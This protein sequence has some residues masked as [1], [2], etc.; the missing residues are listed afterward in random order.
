ML[1]KLETKEGIISIDRVVIN[2]IIAE[3]I[4]AFQGKVLISNHKGKVIGRS[5]K[6]NLGDDK[7]HSEIEIGAKGLDIRVYIVIRFGTSINKVTEQ[8]LSTIKGNIEEFLGIEV[9]SIAIVVTGMI[10]KQ[11]AKRNIVV[12]G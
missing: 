6:F 11:V 10:S 1:Y 12:K 8:L 9:N 3:A 2:R 5:G 4:E 7:S